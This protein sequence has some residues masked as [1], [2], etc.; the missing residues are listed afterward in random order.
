MNVFSSPS[1]RVIRLFFLSLALL[2][3]GLGAWLFFSPHS[4][5][6]TI[7]A[8]ETYN[9]HYERDI[10]TFYFAFA[11]GAWLAAS[12]ASWRVPVLSITTLQYA[13]HSVNHGI[14]VDRANNSWAGPFDVISLTLATLQF[15]ALLWLLVRHEDGQSAKS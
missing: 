11:L 6:R 12:R 8:F 5:F 2:H 15:A 3:L 10:A 13:L 9:R 7:G 4:F 1:E 14:D